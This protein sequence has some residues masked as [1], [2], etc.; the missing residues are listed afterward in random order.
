[1]GKKHTGKIIGLVLLMAAI[2]VVLV[3]TACAKAETVVICGHCSAK[4]SENSQYCSNCGGSLFQ[5]DAKPSDII[6]NPPSDSPVTG[7][8]ATDPTDEIVSPTDNTQAEE[9]TTESTPSAEPTKPQET[10]TPTESTTSPTTQP[11][12]T[13]PTLETQECQHPNLKW[14]IPFDKTKPLPTCTESGYY[15]YWCD[16]CYIQF[17]KEVPALGHSG[18]TASCIT[19]AKCTRCEQEYGELDSNLHIHISNVIRNAV[20]ATCEKDG[21]EGDLSYCIDCDKTFIM[22]KVLKATG[23]SISTSCAYGENKIHEY[24]RN[25]CGYSSYKDLEPINFSF[26]KIEPIGA[27]GGAFFDIT[28]GYGGAGGKYTADCYFYFWNG[29]KYQTDHKEYTNIKDYFSFLFVYISPNDTL[30]ITVSDYYGHS[31]TKNFICVQDPS[32]PQNVIL[33]EY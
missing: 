17:D 12:T 14:D 11:S 1:M 8:P 29:I 7:N 4:V 19:R 13:P 26:S 6:T 2:L 18:G 22:G 33:Q 24:C 9:N 16:D 21:Y 32:N 3:C 31:Q 20:P 10:Q 23:H 15:G 28:G 27:L 30:T 25:N 5:N